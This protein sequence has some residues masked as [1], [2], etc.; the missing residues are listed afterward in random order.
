MVAERQRSQTSLYSQDYVAWVEQTVAQLKA[1]DFGQ[2]DWENLI[3]EV[4]DM[5]RR[6]RRRLE[7]NLIVILLHLLKWQYQPHQRSG[8]WK[9]SLREHR[10]RVNRDLTDSPS[11][12]PYLLDI[13][14][15]CYREARNQAADE[16]GLAVDGF[17]EVCPYTVQQVLDA[18]FLP[19]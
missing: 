5:S 4:A 3:E 13:W 2:V 17:C 9:S 11:L 6:E 15:G 12:K 14:E 1:Q 16:T 18:D 8:S 10:R 7:S 19:S